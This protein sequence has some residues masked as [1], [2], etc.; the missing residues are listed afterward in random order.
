MLCTT[1]STGGAE[2]VW[3]K[4]LQT[5]PSAGDQ[6]HPSKGSPLSQRQRLGLLGCGWGDRRAGVCLQHTPL[7]GPT[8]PET[9]LECR[10]RAALA[11]TN[12]GIGAQPH[13]SV[14]KTTVCPRY[15]GLRMDRPNGPR[16]RFVD[17]GPR[18]A[19]KRWFFLGIPVLVL[20]TALTLILAVP[21]GRETLWRMWCEATQDWCLGVRSTL[22]GFPRRTASFCCSLRS[23]L[24]PGE[25][26]TRSGFIL[27]W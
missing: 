16:G 2:T 15:S 12:A 24:R 8:G 10:A 27:F 11:G 19:T 9:V 26:T 20:V 13:T 4:H 1:S 17:N 6:S 7:A 3:G 18:A 22:A 25:T 23:K 14:Q 5:T 21:T